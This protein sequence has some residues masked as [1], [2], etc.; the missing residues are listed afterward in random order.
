MTI[1][2]KTILSMVA[3][4]TRGTQK[5]DSHLVTDEETSREWDR[6]AASHKKLMK[7]FPAGHVEIPNDPDL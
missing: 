4:I 3:Q 6:L 5:A 7:E 1:G 2:S